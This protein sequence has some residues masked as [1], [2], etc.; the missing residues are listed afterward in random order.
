[1]TGAILLAGLLLAGFL[2]L[3]AAPAASYPTST[4]RPIP[5]TAFRPVQD[6]PRATIAPSRAPE[7]IRD[8]WLSPRPSYAARPPNPTAPVIVV[9]RSTA[10]PNPT[11]SLTGRASWYCRAGRSI[12][13]YAHPDGPGADLY[14]AAGPRLRQALGSNWRNQ[15]VTVSANGRSVT[16]VLADWCQCSK[17]TSSEKAIDLYADAFTRLAPLSSGVVRVQIAW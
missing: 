3:S 5:A 7:V 9:P 8:P 15:R 4:I 12:C 14:A 6:G 17:G 2:W 11:S 10:R 16:V 1:M 13:M